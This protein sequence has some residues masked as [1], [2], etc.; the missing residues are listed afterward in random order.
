LLGRKND[1]VNKGELARVATDME[2]ITASLEVGDH[3]AVVPDEGN[4][5]DA[6][7]WILITE[8]TLHAVEE[9]SK[10]DCWG[11]KV[12][13]RRANC[14]RQVLQA[15]GKEYEILCSMR[16]WSCLYLLPFGNCSKV[17]NVAGT[18]STERWEGG[19]TGTCNLY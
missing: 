18:T 13:K 4:S 1:Q 7:F 11:Q 16:C 3:F 8:E 2:A 10:E 14:G 6:D 15:K 12:Y 19:D 9:E 5:E 17:C